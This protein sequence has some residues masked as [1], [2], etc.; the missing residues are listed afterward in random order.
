MLHC[1]LLA[2]IYSSVVVMNIINSSLFLGSTVDIRVVFGVDCR[3]WHLIQTLE[4]FSN[5]SGA[6]ASSVGFFEVQSFNFQ[7]RISI[8]NVGSTVFRNDAPVVRNYERYAQ[9]L[10]GYVHISDCLF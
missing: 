6:S 4:M 7:F 1:I 8:Y 10:S 5:I 2:V 3:F 9:A